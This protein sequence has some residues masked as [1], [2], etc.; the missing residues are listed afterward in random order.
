M[1][2]FDIYAYT[3]RHHLVMLANI[4]EENSKSNVEF[5]GPCYSID[6]LCILM[7]DKYSDDFPSL[8]NLEE[9][10]ICIHNYNKLIGKNSFGE[11][12]PDYGDYNVN[13]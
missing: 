1:R 8:N 6:E 10:I 9:E 12:Y 5:I 2:L 11:N 3:E 4:W 7:Y 13:V